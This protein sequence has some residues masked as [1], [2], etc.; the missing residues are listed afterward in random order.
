MKE[1]EFCIRSAPLES[2]RKALVNVYLSTRGEVFALRQNTFVIIDVVLPTMFGPER[3][4]LVMIL[5]VNTFLAIITGRVKG[6]KG[7]DKLVLVWEAGVV[8]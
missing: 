6:E 4:N 2:S 8:A 7:R 5:P 1:L 3:W